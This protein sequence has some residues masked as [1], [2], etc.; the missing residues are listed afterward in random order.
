MSTGAEN[1]ARRIEV[2]TLRRSVGSEPVRTVST[3]SPESLRSVNEPPKVNR[4]PAHVPA[5][6]GIRGLA[7]LMVL[8]CHATGR[9]F[10]DHANEIFSG[11][12]DRGMLSLARLSWS[13]VDLFFILSGFL[14]TGILFDAKGK[15]HFFRNFYARRTVRI[16]PLYY[17][18]LF[19][20]LII[21][22]QL[23]AAITKGW[24]TLTSSSIWYP[25]YFSNF[26]DAIAEQAGHATDHVVHVAWSLSIEEQ[27]YL[28]WPLVVFLF[29]RKALLRICVGMFFGSMALRLGLLLD[30]KHFLAMGFTPCRLDGLAVGAAIALIARG[31][32]GLASLA[33]PARWIGPLSAAGLVGMILLMFKLGYR[34]GIGHSPGYVFCGTALLSLMFGSIL[35]VAALAEKGTVA[36]RI[37]AHP[38]LRTYGK[39]SYA[40][41]LFHLPIIVWTYNYLFDPLSLRAGGTLLA[42]LLVFYT[43]TFSLSLLAAVL[44]WHVIEKHF[45]KLK[46]YFPMESSRAAS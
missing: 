25:L 17:I 15:S 11:A 39:Y 7:V 40:V 4:A 44:S 41:Y 22:P 21:A 16:F 18:F 38:I 5:L 28:A 33:R 1:I 14:I 20:M 36:N 2:L 42:G 45:L 34:Q 13:G 23:P 35:V 10:G 26:S 27:F 37:F 43:V 32:A 30:A 8:F 19:V 9:P 24:G 31:P 12:F 46:D 29:G 3:Q 6:D